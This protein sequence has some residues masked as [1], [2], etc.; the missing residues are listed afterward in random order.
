[1]AMEKKS[2]PPAY[3]SSDKKPAGKGGGKRPFG[4]KRSLKK[5]AGEC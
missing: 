1:M 4:G 3:G 2:E 5:M